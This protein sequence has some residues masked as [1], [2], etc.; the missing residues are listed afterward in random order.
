M[1]EVEADSALG[2]GELLGDGVGIVGESGKISRN[3]CRK[4]GVRG[5]MIAGSTGGRRGAS[6]SV[7][8]H[9]AATS[10]DAHAQSASASSSDITIP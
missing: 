8:L 2:G 3:R 10:G 4:F 9:G 7:G 6:T 5:T 1:G